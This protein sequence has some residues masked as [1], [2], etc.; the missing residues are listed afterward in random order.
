MQKDS[1]T[2]KVP[3]K[4]ASTLSYNSSASCK[5]SWGAIARAHDLHCGLSRLHNLLEFTGVSVNCYHVRETLKA[6]FLS[7]KELSA[8][9]GSVPVSWLWQAAYQAGINCCIALR[10]P[11]LTSKNHHK[12][13]DWALSNT[14]TD[15]KW[16]LFTNEAAVKQGAHPGPIYVSCWVNTQDH[17]NNLVPMFHSNWKKIMVWAGIAYNYKTLLY[18]IPLAPSS[19][20]GTRHAEAETLTGQKYANWIIDGLLK[21][22]IDACTKLLGPMTVVEDGSPCHT[23]LVAQE[24]C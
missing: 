1:Y 15:W 2:G 14:A 17:L 18:V 22:A 23:V 16:V 5:Q 11:F 7:W 4:L 3:W 10:K 6:P 24:Q 12:Q 9:L 8:V 21:S 19:S 13:Q 20:D